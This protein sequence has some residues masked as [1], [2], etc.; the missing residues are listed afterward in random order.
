V[1]EYLGLLRERGMALCETKRLDTYS[2]KKAR[3]TLYA[4]RNVEKLNVVIG[5]LEQQPDWSESEFL[6]PRWVLEEMREQEMLR[7]DVRRYMNSIKESATW[8]S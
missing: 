5:W 4:A 7:R 1:S 8:L 2:Y 3:Y 6:A